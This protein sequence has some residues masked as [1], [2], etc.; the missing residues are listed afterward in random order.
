MDALPLGR[1]AIRERIAHIYYGDAHT[2]A[3]KPPPAFKL[4]DPAAAK[5]KWAA[6][7]AYQA[8]EAK[9]AVANLRARRSPSASAILLL[10]QSAA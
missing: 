7:K 4:R 10:I 2:R 3:M 1:R 8:H 6:I 5:K 9:I